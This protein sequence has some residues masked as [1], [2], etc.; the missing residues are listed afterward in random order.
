MDELAYIQQTT[1]G[2]YILGGFS[3]SNISGDKTE[4]SNG[5]DDYWIVKTDSLG[6]IVWQ[7]TI[8]GSSIDRLTSIQQ[9]NNGGYIL[10]GSSYSKISGDK[11]ENCIDCF[12]SDYWIVM[13]D[14]LGSIQWQNTIGGNSLDAL[15]VIE[16]AADG[17][18][19]VGG[20]SSSII[21]G[22]RRKIG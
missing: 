10:G 6:S 17:G 19:I 18:F 7:N 12:G 16:K 14:Y 9:I 21:F 5:I 11:A 1:D 15:Q 3:K 4:N 20:I 8:G 2:G 22:D 13:V